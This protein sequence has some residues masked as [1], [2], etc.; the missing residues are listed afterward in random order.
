M[1][2]AE[3]GPTDL[4]VDIHPHV[5]SG[6]GDTYP[7]RPLGGMRSKWSEQR[8]ASWPELSAAMVE[9]GVGKAAVVQS[10]TTYGHDNSYLADCVDEARDRITGVASVDF[11]ESDVLDQI[12]YWI[13]DRGLAGLRLFTW[14]TTMG[15]ANWL[16]DERTQP[17]WACV[18]ERGI[19]VCVQ[20]SA[21]GLDQLRTV[22]LRFPELRI[23]LDHVAMAEFDDGPPYRDAER[24]RPF[25]DFGGVHLKITSRT[26]LSG[27]K[28]TGGAA[29]AVAEL[30]AQFGSQRIA[31]G[32]NW[33]A[34]HGT[35]A[36]LAAALR[37]AL[38]P[39]GATDARNIASATALA[40]YPALGRGAAAPEPS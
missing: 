30:V 29:G 4:I 19:P 18:A 25:A 20:L 22:L 27:A 33:P 26:L 31:W 5:I 7:K 14:G 10:S 36:T 13:D 28:S 40:L 37:E 24:V 32:S 2:A 12:R 1:A 39:L 9:A 35:L 16:A 8:P 6:D 11:T 3:P 15:Q 23:V 21:D 17:A 38:E 34:S